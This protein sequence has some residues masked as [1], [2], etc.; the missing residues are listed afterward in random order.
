MSLEHQIDDEFDH[1]AEVETDLMR[2]GVVKWFIRGITALYAAA[3]AVPA[4]RFLRTG[5]VEEGDVQVTQITLNDAL[6]LKPGSFQMFRF[7]SKPAIII[8]QNETDFKAYLATCTHLGCTVSYNE[9]TQRIACACHGGQYDPS[10]GKNIAGPPP[11]PLTALKT[12]V[13]NGELIVKA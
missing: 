10:T 1:Q 5:D 3:F 7:G 8:R 4:Y 9:G 2:R 13:A 6:N 11:A 12:E